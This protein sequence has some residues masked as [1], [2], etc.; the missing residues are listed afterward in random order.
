M[1]QTPADL[2][3]GRTTSKEVVPHTELEIQ[4]DRGILYL[5][6]Q[7]GTPLIKITGLPKTMPQLVDDQRH[8]RQLTIEIHDPGAVCNWGRTPTVVTAAYPIRH[9]LEDDSI[10][11]RAG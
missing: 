11:V 3:S 5:Y 8:L 6:A 9:P 1:N 10:P 4:H 7:D 2:L